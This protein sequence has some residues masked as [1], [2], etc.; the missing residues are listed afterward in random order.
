M[1]DEDDRSGAYTDENSVHSLIKLSDTE[2]LRHLEYSKCTL[3]P[4]VSRN[5]INA[6]HKKRS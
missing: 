2:L 1:Q 4:S 3:Q 6:S 5:T